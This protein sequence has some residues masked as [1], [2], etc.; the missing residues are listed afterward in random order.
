VPRLNREG[1]L[2]YTVRRFKAKSATRAVPTGEVEFDDAQAYLVGRAEE[3]IYYTLETLTVSRLG[4]AVG[5]MGLARKAHLEALFRVRARRAFGKAIVDHPLVRHDLTDLAVRVAGGTALLFHAVQAFD[6]A[7]H[8]RPPY[9]A[10]YHLARF[11]SHLVKNRT[12]EHAA[13]ATLLAMELFGGLGFMDEYAIARLHREA[14]VTPIWEGTSNIQALDMLEAMAKK[15]AHEP[16]L[17]GIHALTAGRREPEAKL[18][19][20]MVEK[21]LA[22][23][24]TSEPVAAQWISKDA[25]RR[26][27]DA[28]CVAVLLAVAESGGE[29]YAK[30][31]A[32]YAARFL[33]GQSYPAWAHTFE[34]LW[35]LPEDAEGV[36]APT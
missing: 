17:E 10:Q 33:E 5:A 13:A 3:G 8:D 2:N 34:A 35:A 26:L 23:L 30:M 16:F 1:E 29:R 24:S 22:E 25:L 14:L 7:W 9:T 28:T 19:R 11:L 18:A 36:E 27:A 20:Q 32:L 21:T 31:A 12:A 6:R 4:N 15:G